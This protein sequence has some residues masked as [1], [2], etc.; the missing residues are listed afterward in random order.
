MGNR[1]TSSASV[2]SEDSLEVDDELGEFTMSPQNRQFA[3][4]I[5]LMK[6]LVRSES[7]VCHLRRVLDIAPQVLFDI[8]KYAAI[9]DCCISKKSNAEILGKSDNQNHEYLGL[10]VVPKKY[11][12]V[13]SVVFNFTSRD[14]GWSSFPEQRGT[15]DGYSWLEAAFSIDEKGD[16]SELANTYNPILFS[17]R[18]TIQRNIHAGKVYEDGSYLFD[19]ESTFVKKINSLFKKSFF[20]SHEN[21]ININFS[22]IMRSEYPGWR[23]NV[24]NGAIFVTFRFQATASNL[25]EVM[26]LLI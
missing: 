19:E 14:Q 8:F 22:M 25:A 11:F 16:N 3:D 1:S 4:L 9:L 2:S 15:R 24:R 10:T 7:D 21:K 18:A 20:R 13:C 26:G 12:E 5:L 23:C 17:H 6:S